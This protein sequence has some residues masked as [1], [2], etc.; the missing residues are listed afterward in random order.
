VA[1]AEKVLGMMQADGYGEHGGLLLD[2]AAVYARAGQVRRVCAV[3]VATAVVV[4]RAVCVCVCC[5]WQPDTALQYVG[6]AQKAGVRPSPEPYA[7]VI[8]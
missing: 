2:L 1:V 4:T 5:A 6:K 3:D 7:A 8:R